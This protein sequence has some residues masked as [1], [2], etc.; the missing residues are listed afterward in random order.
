MKVIKIATRKSPLAQRQTDLVIESICSFHPEVQ[1]EKVLITTSG[2]KQQKWSL[3]EKGGKGLFTKEI[4]DAL[5]EGEADLAVHS[6]KD[7]PTEMPEG[8][9]IRGFLPRE[10]PADMLIMREGLVDGYPKEIASSSPRR[11]VQ[12]KILM[13]NA[14]WCEI[15]GNVDTRIKKVAMGSTDATF[16]ATAG[17]NRLGIKSWDGVI[18]R[19]L[20]V[21]VMVPAAGQGAV[22]LQM[23]RNDLEWLSEIYC[24]ETFKAVTIER[25]L[26]IAMEGG[27]HTA[28]GGHFDGQ[29]LHVFHEDWGYHGFDMSEAEQLNPELFVRELIAKFESANH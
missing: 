13:P 6:A 19:K 20:P 8:L 18:F 14:V 25:A 23:R 9:E 22:A 7:L 10:D 21:K 29:K 2:D 12:G 5:L 26:L 1:C 4:E 15:R 27:C 28:M 16:L 24:E 11:R 17:L 3:A